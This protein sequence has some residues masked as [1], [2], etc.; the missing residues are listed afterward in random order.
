MAAHSHFVNDVTPLDAENLNSVIRGEGE[1][2]T[3]N[4][5]IANNFYFRAV[6]SGG[7]DR[8]VLGI[9]ATD[10]L[11]LGYPNSI[12]QI[13]AATLAAFPPLSNNAALRAY[14]LAS[15]AQDIIKIDNADQ[16]VL[17]NA[18]F[19][20][21]LVGSQINSLPALVNNTP[22]RMV[23]TGSVPRNLIVLDGSDE[24][25]IGYT[26][27]QIHFDGE[28][29]LTTPVNLPNNQ[30]ITVE[31]TGG[32]P[33]DLLTLDG[34]DI[35]Q[36]GYVGSRLAFHPK[37]TTDLLLE[38]NLYLQGEDNTATARNLIGIDTNNQIQ[39]GYG[40][41]NLR[42]NPTNLELNGALSTN[43]VMENSILLFGLD[44]AAAAVPL[45]GMTVNDQIRLG[46]PAYG[47]II[48]GSLDQSL[49]LSN[50]LG[51]NIEDSGGTPHNLLRMTA[52]NVME[53]G[54]SGIVFSFL[55]TF[56]MAPA[57]RLVGNNVYYQAQDTGGT[58]RNMIGIDANNFMQLG[59]A[60]EGSARQMRINP[61][62][63][64]DVRLQ[65]NA[66][67]FMNDKLIVSRTLA[68][69]LDRFLFGEGLAAT[70]SFGFE[71]DVNID[72]FRS[73]LHSNR[74]VI[75][76]D[77]ASAAIDLFLGDDTDWTRRYLA[78]GHWYI[79]PGLDGVAPNLERVNNNMTYGLTIRAGEVGSQ[80]TGEYLNVRDGS[81]TLHILTG[82]DN[83][84][85][86]RMTNI[87]FADSGALLHGMGTS[88]AFGIEMR[89]TGSVMNGIT[90]GT[91]T[92]PVQINCSVRNG[93][94]QDTISGA[95]NMMVI[96]NA[97]T[98]RFIFRANGDAA[99]D[100]NWTVFDDFDDVGMLH[101]LQINLQPTNGI[102]D[103]VAARFGAFAE[104]HREVLEQAGIVKFHD[105]GSPGGFVSL[106]RLPMLLT[107]AVLQ[108]AEKIRRLEAR[109]EYL[110]AQHGHA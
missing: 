22:L 24:I 6:D 90:G 14:N 56:D 101:A 26:G 47:L 43:L 78:G 19:P 44:T 18:G 74:T 11:T 104:R 94:V 34:T 98:T 17:G 85:F 45:L 8:N 3:S 72:A 5:L 109:L 68:S 73:L 96:R 15:V 70:A 25:R 37:I 53:F 27:V 91:A 35:I 10:V 67:I 52:A 7:F 102:A 106:T 51:I 49:L 13:D 1:T 76:T 23:D 39:V 60:A 107:G 29:N 50:N 4:I 97:D 21:G 69:G 84:T 64:N 46:D 100:I 81:R 28:V 66:Q 75:S 32:T 82:I 9:S 48:H 38:N 105:D 95:N 89:G 86:F 79:N 57:D 36:L 92:A 20:L 41:V 88:N 40:G 33:Q 103:A 54:S 99:A 83:S 87:T 12:L 2:N 63:I 77:T 62:I 42:I 80:P 16:I 59:D 55:G 58:A 65:G 30:P 93:T 108:S 110:E 61:E 71:T 31:D